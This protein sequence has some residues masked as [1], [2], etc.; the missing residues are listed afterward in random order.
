MHPGNSPAVRAGSTI[1]PWPG[2]TAAG[3]RA[4][5]RNGGVLGSFSARHAQRAW[6]D[7]LVVLRNSVRGMDSSEHIEAL[8]GLQFVTLLAAHLGKCARCWE[9]GPYGVDT[10]VSWIMWAV[11]RKSALR[12]IVGPVLAESA[13]RLSHRVPGAA[14]TYELDPRR[15]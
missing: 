7:A 13:F 14:V 3:K 2:L 4:A 12:D 11:A 10:P 8:A 1:G 5:A 6:D 15:R 9:T